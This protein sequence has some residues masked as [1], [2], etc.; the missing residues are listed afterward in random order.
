MT[1]STSAMM[2][3]AFFISIITISD[4]FFNFSSVC[5][6]DSSSRM[7]PRTLFSESRRESS[8]SLSLTMYSPYNFMRFNLFSSVSALSFLKYMLRHCSWREL[9][10]TVKFT[11]VTLEHKS[12]VK[13]AD[14]SL[15]IMK[16]LNE[17]A[18]S[19]SWLPTLM[20]TLPP[21]L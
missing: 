14:E 16:M 11:N 3:S 9:C 17:A 21:V 18:K 6:T 15:V 12:G 4:S 2:V 19:I 10:V 8:R 7:D 1:A 5:M 13:M 20:S